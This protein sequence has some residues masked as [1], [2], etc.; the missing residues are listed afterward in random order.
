MLPGELEPPVSFA[1]KH[2]RDLQDQSREFCHF[3]VLMPG[4]RLKAGNV[5]P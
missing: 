2:A 5:L 3:V 1:G 4:E